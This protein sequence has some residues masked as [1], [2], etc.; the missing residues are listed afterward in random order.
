MVVTAMRGGQKTARSDTRVMRFP[1]DVLPFGRDTNR[2]GC[3]QG[4]ALTLATY[5]VHL[6]WTY[7]HSL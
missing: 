2:E 4:R 3:V 5:T 7:P 1:L 6:E